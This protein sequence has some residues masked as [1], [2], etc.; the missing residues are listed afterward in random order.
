MTNRVR[1]LL[2]LV[3]SKSELICGC[4]VLLMQKKNQK[5]IYNNNITISNTC[6]H[7]SLFWLL[8]QSTLGTSR[9][10]TVV[11]LYVLRQTVTPGKSCELFKDFYQK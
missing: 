10:P 6:F 4:T 8:E 1:R 9:T 3:Q 11:T 5:T 2:D 7:S